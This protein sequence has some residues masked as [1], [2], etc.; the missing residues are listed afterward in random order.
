MHTE[1]QR[2]RGSVLF[3]G[4]NYAPEPTGI[5]PYTTGMAEGL[6][7]DGWDVRVITSYPHYPWWEVRDEHRALPARETVEAVDVRRVRHHVPRSP[8]SLR[9]ALFE[10]S[11]GVR[12]LLCRWDSPDVV[13]VVS[14][15]LLASRLIALR[16]RLARIPVV[17]WVQ[18]IYAL[19]VQEA[20]GGTG[21]GAVGAIEASLFAASERV[22]VIH[23]RF[24][25]VLESRFAVRRP[26]DVVRN[27]SHVPEIHLEDAAAV[28]ARRGWRSDEVIVLHA[29][30]MGAKQGLENVVAAAEVA[31]ARGSRL[32]F[33]LMG[34][35]GRRAALEALPGADAVSFV[36]PL[37][38]EEFLSTLAAADILLVNER[39]GMTDMSVPSKLTSYFATGRPVIA[40]VDERS[41]TRA[42][43]EAS[44]AGPV[45][46]PAMP[47]DLV[48][49]AEALAA[50]PALAH[51]YGVAGQTY[52]R[53]VLTE[54]AAVAAFARSL[55][56]AVSAPRAAASAIGAAQPVARDLAS[57]HVLS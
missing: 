55:T 43:M 46:A 51:R 29:G 30:A 39:P 5:S 27:W 53:R 16:A 23:R 38:E 41:T 17:T 28:R 47:V 7:R 54:H 52:R 6:A 35:G 37:P 9:R 32:R 33:V 25:Q 15:A 56:A 22:V 4:L 49:A 10:T 31:R 14:P 11:F 40:A 36:D 12:A 18:D 45:I 44:Q 13:V 34:D 21:A 42:E 8:G 24:R 57:R 19:G 2:A 3:V 26:I 48:D 1:N 50:D 20:G